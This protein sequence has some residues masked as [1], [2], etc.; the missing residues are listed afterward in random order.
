MS[1]K[2]TSNEKIKPMLRVVIP[3][4]TGTL[5]QTDG[6]YSG[7]VYDLW[8]KIRKTLE[9]EYDFEETFPLRTSYTA[10]TKDIRDG[11]WDLGIGT[12][13]FTK[14]R[15]EAINYTYPIILMKDSILYVPKENVTN[16]LFLSFIFSA[17][18]D[19]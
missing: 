7:V 2:K 9:N 8:K 11:K 3:V 16:G 4:G 1:T 12:W 18:L 13:F 5:K 19:L 10:M 14:E 17:C 15:A 6:T